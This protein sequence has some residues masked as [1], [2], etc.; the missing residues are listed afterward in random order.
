MASGTWPEY[1]GDPTHAANA[2][3][4]IDVGSVSALRPAWFVGTQG[5][6]TDTPA[7][8]FG[9]V[10]AGDYQGSFYAINQSAGTVEWTFDAV[11][12]QSCFLD[13]GSGHGDSHSTGFGEITSSPA[14][15]SV[16]GRR[17]V[18][19]GAGGSLFALDA[20]SGRCLWADDTDPGRPNSAIEIESSPVVDTAVA[21]PEVI[22]GNDDNS[23]AG[24][25]VTGIMA[26][27]AATG[28]LLWKYEPE[29]DL[30]LRPTQFGGSDALA[31]SC[32]DGAANP[33]CNPGRIR[34]LAPNDPKYADACGDVWSSPAL[35]TSFVDP[36]GKNRYQGSAPAPPSGWYPKR[37]TGTGRSNDP[38]RPD[39]LVVFGTGNCSAD[40]TPETALA[41][42]DYVD[43]QAMFALDPVTGVRLWD[44]VHPYDLYDSNSNE[45]WAGDDDFGSSPVL[46]RLPATSL[47]AG[48]CPLEG[49]RG[50]KTAT[51]V[52]EGAKSG[53]AFGLCAASGNPVWSVQ[54][55]QPGQLS[56]D[57]VGAVGGFIGSPSLGMAGG[58]PT[59][60]FTSAIPTPLSNDGIRVPG[61]GDSNV[62][63]CPGT[64]VPAAPSGPPPACPDTTL[65]GNPERLASLHAVDAATGR[66]VYQAPSV[67]TYAAST[68]SN[69]V[70]FLP[71]SLAA[72]VIAYDA[73][74][75]RPL[76]AAPV[77]AVPASG[78]SI[79]G[80]AIYFGTG[81]TAG[82]A[83][84]ESVPPQVT[85]IWCFS[86]AP[87]ELTVSPPGIPTP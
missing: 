79:A 54:A 30:T 41:H 29:R 68:Y 61:D 7:V 67:P 38:S 72:G 25:A 46:A 21:P 11:A 84:A 28:A 55:A 87:S 59:V 40:P 23:G 77:G 13:A 9:S 52:I 81:E 48:A 43:N 8:A 53:T 24:I 4:R 50:T 18:Y 73:N 76:W 19:F 86:T 83:G 42:G 16:A 74:S 17:M 44:F 20:S 10:F 82:T 31:L 63:S 3:S 12:H 57:L 78:A 33:Y 1:Q 22:V 2:C 35:D 85:G 32:G 26:F 15:A 70:V 62:S 58:R 65:P 66:I 36:A 39:G 49:G 37:I 34:D 56:G 47:H 80:N 71:D 75:G 6:V 64:P 60:F 69:G 27:N 14:V 5:A 51:L 45:P